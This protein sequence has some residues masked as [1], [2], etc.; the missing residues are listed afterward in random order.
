MPRGKVRN[1][2]TGRW[3]KVNG[4]TYRRVFGDGTSRKSR[5]SRRRTTKKKRRPTRK[6]SRLSKERLRTLIPALRAKAKAV[7]GRRVYFEPI[8]VRRSLSAKQY[9][10][11]GGNVGDLVRLGEGDVKILRLRKSGKPYWSSF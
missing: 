8:Q 4:P 7:G 1:P 3:I 11:R 10:A 2:E 5:K 9:Y 6:S